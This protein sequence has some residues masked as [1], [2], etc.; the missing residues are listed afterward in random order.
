MASIA[1]LLACSSGSAWL[2]RYCRINLYAVH[3]FHGVAAFKYALRPASF[4]NIVSA[5]SFLYTWRPR[6]K[7]V[8][9]HWEGTISLFC[10]WVFGRR[11]ITCCWGGQRATVYPKSTRGVLKVARLFGYVTSCCPFRSPSTRRF[12]V[13]GTSCIRLVKSMTLD[14]WY[15]VY[16]YMDWQ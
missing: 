6:K 3:H 11:L 10:Q 7:W 9:V 14:L 15:V 5:V 13:T 12:E 4:M 8:E 16:K 2:W 1:H